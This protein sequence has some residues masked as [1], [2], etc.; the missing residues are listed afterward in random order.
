ML[1]MYW[2]PLTPSH[3]SLLFILS[4]SVLFLSFHR[5]TVRQR[6]WVGSRGGDRESEIGGES[7]TEREM[8]SERERE[9]PRE[10]GSDRRWASAI[11]AGGDVRLWVVNRWLEVRFSVAR[12][13]FRRGRDGLAVPVERGWCRLELRTPE[14]RW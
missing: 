10:R 8:L 13:N 2:I 9:M 12:T 14:M 3:F 6:E 5:D 4:S 1:L 11:G 7:E